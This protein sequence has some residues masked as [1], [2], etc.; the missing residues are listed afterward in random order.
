MRPGCVA[1]R[2]AVICMVGDGGAMYAAIAMDAGAQA[3]TS[4]RLCLLMHLQILRGEFGG[5][6]AGEPGKRALDM[7]KI[8]NPTIDFVNAKAMGVPGRAVAS[9]DDFVKVAEAVPSRGRG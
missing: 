2:T 4:S 9:V 5:V 3:S 8:D 7:L 6:G 1:C